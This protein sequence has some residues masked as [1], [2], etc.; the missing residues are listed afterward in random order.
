MTIT[1][2]SLFSGIGGLELGLERA[3]QDGGF[4][5]DT[6]FQCEADEWCRGILAHHWPS[7]LRFDDVR[8]VG[9]DNATRCDVLCGGFPCQDVS[10]AGKGVGLAGERSGLWFEFARVVRELRPRVV[11]VENVAALAHRGLDAVLGS[12]SEAGYDAV[13]FDVRASDVGAPHRRERLFIVAWRVADAAGERRRPDGRRRRRP[14]PDA[15]VGGEDVSHADRDGLPEP[16][17][18]V[19][20]T[21]ARASG[22]KGVD[23][24][25]CMGRD[26]DGLPGGLDLTAHRWPVGPGEAQP[27]GE[28]PRVTSERN[29]RRRRLKALGNAVVPQVAYVVGCVVA[30]ILAGVS[31]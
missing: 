25:P 2:G 29:E 26:A 31:P 5:V 27:E 16:R 12:L 28:P 13:W 10:C 11:V 18:V 19:V 14:L 24:Q 22:G 1:I 3:L 8:A 17:A 6:V 20:T 9:A 21:G 7:A 30:R 23:A 15:G 4:N